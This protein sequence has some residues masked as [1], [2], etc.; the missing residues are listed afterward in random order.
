[1]IAKHGVGC[2]DHASMRAALDVELGLPSLGPT[3][4]ARADGAVEQA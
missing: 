1:V 4:I 2:A 3:G